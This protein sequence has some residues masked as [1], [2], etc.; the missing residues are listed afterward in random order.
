MEF[1]WISGE[2]KNMG[3]SIELGRF[4]DHMDGWLMENPIQ[5]D[6]WEKPRK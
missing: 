2:K 4:L 6:N 1:Q 5:M 3:K